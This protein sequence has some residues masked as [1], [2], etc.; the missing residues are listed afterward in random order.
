M[1]TVMFAIS[2]T[3]ALLLSR[4]AVR[5]QSSALDKA[6][7]SIRSVDFLNF[8]YKPRCIPGTVST[9]NGK[10]DNPHNTQEDVPVYFAIN[11]VIYGDIRADGS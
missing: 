5:G 4:I 3:A 7:S 1:R 8:T 9:Q 10:Y 2:L 6:Y 11:D